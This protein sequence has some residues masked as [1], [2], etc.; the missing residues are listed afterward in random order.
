MAQPPKHVI[1]IVVVFLPF[2]PSS[3]TDFQQRVSG[4]ERGQRGEHTQKNWRGTSES[5]ARVWNVIERQARA[6]GR[7][8][9]RFRTLL[10]VRKMSPVLHKQKFA[11]VSGL[12]SA[13]YCPYVK[14]LYILLLLVH[15]SSIA[16]RKNIHNKKGLT[17]LL[18]KGWNTMMWTGF[19]N[20][21]FIPTNW[22]NSCCSEQLSCLWSI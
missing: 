7:Q 6:P 15:Y 1:L 21:R 8:T 14:V 11:E 3:P 10:A 4:L 19:V 12:L 5:Y 22:I 18:Y 20:F 9:D 16:V 13:I 17:C 2:S